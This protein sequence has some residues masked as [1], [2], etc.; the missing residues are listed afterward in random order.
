MGKWFEIQKYPNVWE[1]GQKCIEANYELN[2]NGSITVVNRAV[3]KLY[4][5]SI[6]L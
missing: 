1:A 6:N 2:P 4:G 3:L 5:I